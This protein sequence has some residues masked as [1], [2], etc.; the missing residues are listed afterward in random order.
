M[1]NKL[2]LI[3]KLKMLLI[4]GTRKKLRNLEEK[5]TEKTLN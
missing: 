4:G 1:V 2:T 3:G 5:R